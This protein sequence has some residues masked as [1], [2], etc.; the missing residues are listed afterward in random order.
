MDDR[1]GAPELGAAG[2]S[3]PVRG[4]IFDS[5][6]KGWMP[7]YPEGSLGTDK[8][9]FVNTGAT[10][11]SP[12]MMFIW[13]ANWF[14]QAKG[15]GYV[16][17]NLYPN[18]DLIV[19]VN[20]QMDTTALYADIVLPSASHY[21]KHDINTTDMHSFC[22]PFNPAIPPMY[23]SRTD[24]QIFQALAAKVQERAIARGFT[25]YNDPIW[26]GNRDLSTL[27]DQFTA[28]GALAAD[29]DAAQFI[30][31]NAP[32]TVGM[33]MDGITTKPQRFNELPAT[34]NWTSNLHPGRPYTAFLKN[35]EDKDPYHT[36]TGRQQYLIEHEWFVEAGEALPTYK[37]PVEADDYPLRYNTPHG[38]WSIHSTWRNAKQMLRL[39]RGGPICYMHPTDMVNRGLS[40]DDWVRMFNDYGEVVVRVKEW[41]SEKAGRVTM[42][43]GWERYLGV[44]GQMANFNSVT[45]IRIKPTQLAGGYGQLHFRLN[46]W[47]PTGVQRD[48][49]VEVESYTG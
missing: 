36:L 15:N 13:R 29:K 49:R 32:E 16:E 22:H 19:D 30:L 46:Y 31:D 34:T 41:Q 20:F 47:G 1:M 33:T 6:Q 7:L 3:Q 42:Y 40:D 4:Y 39:N 25:S 43:H 27:S 12:K 35:T 2:L 14:N 26:G 38:R 23:D 9:A 5:V 45:P 10:V 18:L 11:K 48:V 21:E 44:K 17:D 8:E 24:W 28:N 37:A